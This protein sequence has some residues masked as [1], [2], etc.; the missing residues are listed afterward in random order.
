LE[1]HFLRQTA[2]IEAEFRANDDNGAAGVVDALAKKVLAE[3]AL[4]ALERIGQGLERSV[5][6]STE[7]AAT[8]AVVKQSVNG[9][10]KHALFVADDDVRRAK[11]HELLQPVVA[12]DDAAIEV[13]QVGR[14][15]T[16]AVQRNEGAQLRRKH[17]DDVENHP[18]GLVPGLAESFENLQALGV[19]NALLEARIGLHF[20]AEFVGEF[21]DFDAAEKFLDGFRAHLGNKLAGI[22]LREFAVFLFLKDLT[23]LKDG[24]FVRVND[25]ERFE[26]EDAFEV[27]HRD[28][29]QIADTA[30]QALEEPD[31]RAGR[32]Q[33]NV[34]EAFAADFRKRD[35]D[36]ALIADDATVL[37]ALVLAA[38][39][40]PVGNG[41]KNFGAEK[42]V[43]LGLERA[44]VDGL[45]LGDFAVGPGAN[46]FRTRQ[47]DADGIEISD[48][49]GAIIRAAAIQGC[50]LPPWLSPGLRS[51]C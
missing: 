5:V 14:S 9:F 6:R 50:F 33:L 48:Q 46:F 47:R 3:A 10:L 35:F 8:A 13:V 44:V 42:A 43:A 28:V 51:V 12:V 22:L 29:K 15:E 34:A 25:N 38:Q 23:L 4:F 20:F 27:A 24:D 11:F 21:V 41:A 7:N 45:G 17:G 16:G 31:V 36:A 26:I 37:H 49:T 32:G 2:L 30:G 1:R 39:A 18:F 40:F 19:L